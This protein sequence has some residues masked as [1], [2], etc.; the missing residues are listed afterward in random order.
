MERPSRFRWPASAAAIGA[1]VLLAGAVAF[2]A[3]AIT[4]H[5]SATLRIPPGAT[6]TLVVPFPD[7]LK[8]GNARYSGRSGVLAPK[9]GQKGR[10]PSLVKVKILAAEP[11][12]GGS[13][14]QARARNGNSAGTA[15]VRLYVT[16]TTVEPLPHS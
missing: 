15:A 11:V 6:G 7:A 3:T 14:Y 9:P 5:A 2:A 4:K 12:L 10:A 16:A 1:L 8:Y 13:E